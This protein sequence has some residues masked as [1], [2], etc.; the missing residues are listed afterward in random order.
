MQTIALINQK[1][2]GGITA[3]KRLTNNLY[4]SFLLI[5]IKFGG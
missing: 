4:K 2:R 1:G 5:F 3:Q